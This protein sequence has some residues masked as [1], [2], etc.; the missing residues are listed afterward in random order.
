MSSE[1]KIG[2]VLGVFVVAVC[3]W[4]FYTRSSNQQDIP[5]PADAD[6][7]TD[8][9]GRAERATPMAAPVRRPGP[10][11]AKPTPP[12]AHGAKDKANGTQTTTGRPENPRPSPAR[13]NLQRHRTAPSQVDARGQDRAPARSQPR[14]LPSQTKA[15]NAGT[16]Q[17]APPASGGGA[18]G[19][20]PT[21]SGSPSRAD[22]PTQADTLLASSSLPSEGPPTTPPQDMPTAEPQPSTPPLASPGH[23]RAHQMPRGRDAVS[24]V[25]PPSSPPDREHTVQAG[26]S[27][28]KIA[29]Q[30]YG[31]QKYMTYLIQANPQIRDPRR[32][33]VGQKLR[34][35][36]APS[37]ASEAPQAATDAEQD[38]PFERTYV[39]QEGDS[40]YEI[41][42][43]LLGDG[44]RWP[45]VYE[46]N[47]DEVGLDPS[48]LRVGQVLKVP[49]Q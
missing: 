48:N 30:Y 47:K 18:S 17:H 49:L 6:R 19:Q 27:F 20:P 4:F 36:P 13:A 35:P 26:D 40:F 31:S 9:T 10:A 46:M 3:A 28:A 23:V 37:E 43:R 45:E 41:A 14:H 11:K 42:R 39:V 15:P 16:P 32:L 8:T 21:E 2:A 29:E 22:R 12:P 33:S 25:K 7:A 38:R 5:L 24:V 1:L 44:T 34:I